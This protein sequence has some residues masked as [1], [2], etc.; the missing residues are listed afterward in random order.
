MRAT[1]LGPA[2]FLTALLIGLVAG[3]C[4]PHSDYRIEK[5]C[6]DYCARAVDCND[7]VE[8]DDCVDDCINTAN[9]C[10]SDQDIENG[11]DILE[12]CAEESCNDVGACVIEAWVE[13]AL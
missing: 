9:D 11:L 1:K 7:N 5:V 3:A 4:G 6:K 13:C 8:F 10:D 2:S 12:T